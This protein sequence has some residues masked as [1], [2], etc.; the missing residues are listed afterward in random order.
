MRCDETL[1]R[2]LKFK[3]VTTLSGMK[4]LSPLPWH[5]GNLNDSLCNSSSAEAQ[6]LVAITG[7]GLTP[8]RRSYVLLLE[9]GLIFPFCT[10]VLE[11]EPAYLSVAS[12]LRARGVRRWE[13][14]RI[15][16]ER[17]LFYGFHN[18]KEK[19]Y[20]HIFRSITSSKRKLT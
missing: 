5:L 20:A 13:G 15:F 2:V 19:S 18:A 8:R 17:A 12:R 9:E 11:R 4:T 6:V 16:E 10:H 3:V 1:F 14:K 7:H